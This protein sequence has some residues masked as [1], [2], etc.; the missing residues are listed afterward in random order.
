MQNCLVNIIYDYQTLI[1]GILAIFAALIGGWFV[2]KSS[3]QPLKEKRA[4]E[5]KNLKV[6]QRFLSL[7]LIEN[8]SNLSTKAKFIS[9]QVYVSNL[10]QKGSEESKNKCFLTLETFE[11]KWELLSTFPRDI[12]EDI[13]KL[14]N[15][16]VEH[17]YDL[18]RAGATFGSQDF[19]NSIIDRLNNI[20]EKS[21]NLKVKL[22]SYEALLI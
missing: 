11:T 3:Y 21:K 16:L 10:N 22:M 5:E 8:L 20:E 7:V 15:S 6:L 18:N 19:A 4:Q 12:L 1:S 2:W 9:S 17:N 14:Q 13:V